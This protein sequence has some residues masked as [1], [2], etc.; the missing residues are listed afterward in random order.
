LARSIRQIVRAR[1]R[2]GK[3]YQSAGLALRLRR[4]LGE[5]SS[6]FVRVLQLTATAAAVVHLIMVGL[7]PEGRNDFYQIDAPQPFSYLSLIPVG[8]TVGYPQ[9]SLE[10]RFLLYKV[11]T[12]NGSID[13]GMVPQLD[14]LHGLRYD[15]WARAGR[16]A[17]QDYPELHR[18]VV[19]Y[20]LLQLPHPPLKLELYAARWHPLR[21]PG[22]GLGKGAPTGPPGVALQHLGTY[23][24]LQEVWK[25]SKQSRGG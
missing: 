4:W 13:S 19:E 18:S 11:Y 12:Q 6:F 24:G 8:D 20:L 10:R 7:V 3:L 14:S 17:G 16:V 25:P 23:D 21:K 15:R 1:R 5:R 2:A 22:P 9:T